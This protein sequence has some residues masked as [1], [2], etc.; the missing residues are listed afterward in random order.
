[1][2]QDSQYGSITTHMHTEGKR[3]LGKC[4]SVSI[5]SSGTTASTRPLVDAGRCGSAVK[6]SK[7]NRCIVFELLLSKWGVTTHLANHTLG[8]THTSTYHQHPGRLAQARSNLHGTRT[9]GATSGTPMQLLTRSKVLQAEPSC[10]SPYAQGPVLVG[11]APGGGG[12]ATRRRC[13]WSHTCGRP[14][15]HDTLVPA[16]CACFSS[17]DAAK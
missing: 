14:P 6:V 9:V 1:M 10:A 8:D 3:A 17:P 16:S 12:R 11:P 2:N 15:R 4:F 7:S 5:D 13:C